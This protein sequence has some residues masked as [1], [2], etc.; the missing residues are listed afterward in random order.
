ICGAV[1]YAHRH[2]IV[3][4]DL[5][6]ANVLVDKAGNPVLLDFGVARALGSQDGQAGYC[7]PSYASPE[8]LAGEAVSAASDVYSL[9]IMLRELL[10]PLRVPADL[11][12]IADKACAP[13]PAARY[14]S[15]GVMAEDL[16][17][18]VVNLPVRERAAHACSL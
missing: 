8:L 4:C 16:R 6:P 10:A 9:G 5:K 18:Y 1:D 7:T 3:H 15:L 11:D 12:A 2:M 17:L 13:E 14:A